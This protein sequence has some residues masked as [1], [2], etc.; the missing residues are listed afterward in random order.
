MKYL[1]ITTI[2]AVLLVGTVFADPIHDAAKTG[3][4][5]GVKAELDKGVDANTKDRGAGVPPLL[6]AALMGHVEV[7]ELLIANGAD[8][9]GTDKYGNTPLHY[10]AHHGRKETTKL[11]ITKGADVNVKRDNGKTPLD[12]AK[13][14]PEIADLLR[15]HGCRIGTTYCCLWRRP[16]WRPSVTRCWRGCEYEGWGWLD[17]FALFG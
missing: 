9:D 8:L 7:A 11:L 15:K 3:D 4:L 10:A 13:H 12:N 5:A 6:W 16:C 14:K 2:T 17:S 1:L